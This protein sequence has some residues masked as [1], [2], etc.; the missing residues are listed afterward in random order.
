MLMLGLLLMLMAV[1]SFVVEADFDCVVVVVVVEADYWWLILIVVLLLFETD[2]HCGAVL[3]LMLRLRD[4]CRCFCRGY[5]LI[6]VHVVVLAVTHVDVDCLLVLAA[7]EHQK[8]TAQ[9]KRTKE[10][11]NEYE[12]K[13]IQH[14]EGMKHF[15]EQV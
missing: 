6:V 4:W 9:M 5:L 8:L 11:F 12:R 2:L 14:Q 13:D 7:G 1:L 10:E 15:K 3:W